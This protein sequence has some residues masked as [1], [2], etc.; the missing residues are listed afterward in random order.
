M[1][2][3]TDPDSY[4]INVN[5][6]PSTEEVA[7]LAARLKVHVIFGMLEH[8]QK[9]PGVFYN[10]A[11]VVG[12]AGILGAYRKI[13]PFAP[14]ETYERGKELPIFETPY[15][16]IGIGICYDTY[17]FP[18]VC[19]SYAVRGV[20]LYLNPTAVPL[21]LEC[22]D[23]AELC[24]NMLGARCVENQMFIASA[25]IVGRENVEGLG[26][27]DFLGKSTIVGPK[28]GYASYQV[29]QNPRPD[30]VPGIGH[31]NWLPTQ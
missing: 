24:M 28:R 22:N 12:P 14:F 17:C 18:E 15:G 21:G 10:A 19:R 23:E 8:D 6:T 9:D 7:E 1:A 25:G 4:S 2:K 3:L 30:R 16:P 27:V 26:E 13:H 31:W 11:V 5:G 20:R 29:L